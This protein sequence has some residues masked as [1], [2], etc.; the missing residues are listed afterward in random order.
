MFLQ[1]H[2]SIRTKSSNSKI[3]PEGHW[4]SL[5]SFVL[6][7]KSTGL[8]FVLELYHDGMKCVISYAENILN[9]VISVK[10]APT[11]RLLR[12]IS[13]ENKLK[14]SV[15]HSICIWKNASQDMSGCNYSVLCALVALTRLS[16]HLYVIQLSF[17]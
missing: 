8:I 7:W 5:Q 12:G 15:E 6:C 13:W 3:R 9:W 17:L 2:I 16:C 4:T 1:Q 11:R 14:S 10:C